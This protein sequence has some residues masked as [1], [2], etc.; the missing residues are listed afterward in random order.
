MKIAETDSHLNGLEFLLVHKP[1]LWQEIQG[2]VAAV[3]AGKCRTKVSQEKTMKGRL[4]FSPI[5]MNAAFNRLLR[6]KSWDE[7][8]VSYWVTR[9]ERLIRKTLAM[10][11]EEQFEA[12]AQ[13]GSLDAL[14]DEA[15]RDLREG[16][17]TGL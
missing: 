12:D 1:G 15:L 11:A 6:E 2:V 5:D 17:C 7:S 14:A 13:A 9:N 3:D 16:R 8:R 4:L 10:S